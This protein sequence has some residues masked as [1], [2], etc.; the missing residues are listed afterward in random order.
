LPWPTPR[1][2]GPRLRVGIAACDGKTAAIA[3]REGAS[4]KVSL[5]D[6]CVAVLVVPHESVPRGG[7][8]RRV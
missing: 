3:T 1:C 8:G 7:I 4:F 5:A 6:N 2:P